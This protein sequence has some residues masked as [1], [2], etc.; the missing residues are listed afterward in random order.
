MNIVDHFYVREDYK[1]IFIDGTHLYRSGGYLLRDENM[2]L[3]ETDGK[4]YVYL[5]YINPYDGREIL[6]KDQ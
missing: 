6:S 1:I 4:V 3:I 5:K 2:K